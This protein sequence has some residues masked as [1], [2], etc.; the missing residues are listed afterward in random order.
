[1]KVSYQFQITTCTAC[2]NKIRNGFRRFGPAQVNCYFCG[3]TIQTSLT[4]W[5][6]LTQNQKVSMTL[7]ELLAPSWNYPGVT[8]V[9]TLFFGILVGGA[10]VIMPLVF[11]FRN[12]HIPDWLTCSLYC[13]SILVYIL[14][15]NGTRLLKMISE[16][17]KYSMTGTPPIW[18]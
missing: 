18:K 9:L 12:S 10:I 11:L 3:K 1:M 2:G 15:F 17:N 4:P 6:D 5:Q 7:A 16:S 14:L 8:L 13:P